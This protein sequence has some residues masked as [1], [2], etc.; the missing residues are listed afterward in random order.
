MTCGTVLLDAS[1]V[2]FVVVALVAV[3]LAAVALA[4]GNLKTESK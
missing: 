2:V 4:G 3:A 1:T